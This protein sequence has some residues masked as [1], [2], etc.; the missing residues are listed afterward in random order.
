MHR[1]SRGNMPN[2]IEAVKTAAV[3]AKAAGQDW[4]NRSGKSCSLSN[5]LSELFSIRISQLNFVFTTNKIR[6]AIEN[7]LKY[8]I[9]KTMH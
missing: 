7:D 6:L 9:L 5:G 8:R 3:P 1:Q 2:P 4:S